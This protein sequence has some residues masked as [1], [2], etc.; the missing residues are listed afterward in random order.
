MRM[1]TRTRRIEM[2]A[3]PES[4]AKI[5]RAAEL[6]RLSVSAFVLDAAGR[7]AERVLG[8]ADQTIMPA[9][10]FD[11]LIASLDVPDA[12]PRL[13]KAARRTRAF[14]RR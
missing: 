12:A 8:Q 10:E 7:E 9:A 13:R 6:R 11:A 3:D 2:R 14:E 4:E 5:A 1:A